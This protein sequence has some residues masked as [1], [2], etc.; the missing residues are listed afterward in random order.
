MR[1]KVAY[2]GKAAGKARLVR[3]TDDFGLIRD[4]EILVTH[5]TTP[6]LVPFLKGAVAIVTDE[7][8]ISCHAAIVSREL[9]IPCV[10]GTQIATDLIRS[11][12]DIEVDAITGCVKPA[13]VKPLVWLDRVSDGQ[14][15]AV[16]NKAWNLS[17]LPGDIRVPPAFV[18]P[19]EC[20]RQHI[21]DLRARI[22]E[23]LRGIDPS[24]T[25]AVNLVSSEITALVE[26]RDMDG[27]LQGKIGLQVSH[28]CG[29]A[30]VRSSSVQEDR[31]GVSFA[32]QFATYLDVQFPDVA[33]HVARCWASTWSTRVLAYRRRIGLPLFGA[34]MAVIVQEMIQPDWAGVACTGN[35]SSGSPEQVV[36]E[37][38]PGK[39]EDVV[40]GR[41]TPTTLV[42]SK[43]SRRRL[44]DDV[45]D[46]E[47][48]FD[49]LD[50]VVDTSLA[51]EEHFGAPQD[52]EW[53]Y[54]GT[55]YILQ[56][57]DLT[58]CDESTIA[59]LR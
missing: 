56:S 50:Q 23:L 45:E 22:E 10:V 21:S 2:R 7:G 28:L 31:R 8:G 38:V 36:I 41:V 39:G 29:Q 12:D 9:R 3:T 14:R 18:V 53:A 27:V 32:G 17:R 26:Q 58:F 20:F 11:G 15:A 51:I 16:G 30:A 44:D 24:D 46:A 47:L 40:G 59:K 54:C 35:P 33:Q 13:E 57:R 1:G 42:V 55:L 34:D 48:P 25:R 43:T 6:D 4:G 49:V 52:I 5:E 37:A 19:S